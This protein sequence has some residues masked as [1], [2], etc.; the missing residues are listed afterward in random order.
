MIDTKNK[1]PFVVSGASSSL[2]NED[3]QYFQVHVVRAE[4]RWS[5]NGSAQEASIPE[6]SLG[7]QEEAFSWMNPEL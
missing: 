2:I 3:L 4:A 1:I 7:F 6:L 5:G